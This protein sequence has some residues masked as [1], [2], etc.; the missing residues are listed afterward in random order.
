MEIRKALFVKGVVQ[1]VGFRPFVYKT[2]LVNK[3]SGYVRNDADGVTIELQGKKQDVDA[4]WKQL[5]RELPPLAHIDSIETNIIDLNDEQGFVILQSDD[6][7]TKMTLISPDIAVCKECLE[8]LKTK[9]KYHNYFAV[10]CTNCGPRYSIIKTLPYDRVNTSMAAFEMCASCS[11]DY[12]DPTSRRYHAQPISCNSCGPKLDGE[13]ETFA[14]YIKEGKIV[15][16][17]GVGG[18]HIVCD[19]TNNTVIQKL[20]EYKKRPTKP[21]ALMCKDIEQVKT[22]AEVDSKEKELLNSKEAPIV[23]VRKKTDAKLSEL[24]AP[25]IDR[26]GCMLT[27]TPLHHLLFECLENPIV[28]TS[29]NLG[30][31]PI[32]TTKEEIEKK[33][34]FIEHI[35]DFDREIVNAID[36]SL[37]QVVDSKMQVLRLG[38][39]YAPKVVKLPHKS[40]KNILAV[41]ANAKSSIALVMEDNIILSPHIGDLDSLEAFTYFERTYES[42]KGFYDFKP[43][44]II[45]DKHPN[46]LSTKWANSQNLPLQTMQHHLAH[47]YAT[48]AE[49]ALVDDYLG[50]S[51]DGTGFGDDGT[52]W[53]GEIFVGDERKYHFK[54]LKLLGGVKA[55]K[56]PRRIALS[57]LFEKL[58]FDEVCKLNLECVKSFSTTELKMLCQSYEKNLN[59]PLSSSVGRLFDLV[60][61]F[62]GLAQQISYEGESGLLC[63]SIYDVNLT[64]VLEYSLQNGVIE[65]DFFKYISDQDAEIKKFPTLFIN[66]LADIIVT[67]A[68]QEH[69]EV[70]LSGGVFQN[71]TLLELVTSK[72]KKA[73]VKYFFQ[74]TTPINDGGIALGQAYY[75]FDKQK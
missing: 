45:C 38:R 69:M 22:V 33:L 62:A 7:H 46:Y 10:N 75:Y 60:A 4:F 34:P 3:L 50:F 20:R 35:L 14:R 18:F 12:N 48:K 6:S 15:A 8:D 37:V 66:T 40:D 11:S 52:L 51:F 17:K 58:N 47:I 23:I 54:P 32:I 16:I 26:I 31:E 53:G 19:A 30:E 61:S 71:R 55:I 5:H 21:F 68:L 73:G 1:G 63:E 27:Y 9:Q 42:F 64:E 74:Q 56:E 43:Q 59:A 25:N 24:I 67:I 57:L 29:A 49:F 72:L 44:Q 70:I 65:I 39:G 28:A 13:I 41:G 36:D 2:A